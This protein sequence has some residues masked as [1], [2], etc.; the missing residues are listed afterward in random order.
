MT[1]V[2]FCIR[3]LKCSHVY[4]SLMHCAGSEKHYLARFGAERLESDVIFCV[5]IGNSVLLPTIEKWCYVFVG[6]GTIA[7][8]SGSSTGQI[9]IP[10]G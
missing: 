5:F 7:G 8:S 4:L 10:S 6:C 9:N 3:L 1:L 2:A